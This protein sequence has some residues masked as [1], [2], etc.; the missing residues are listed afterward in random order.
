[1]FAFLILIGLTAHAAEI[2][3]KVVL[4]GEPAVNA[5]ISVEGLDTGGSPDSAAYVVD[6]RDL[7]FVPHVVAAR[8]GA[9]L[10][11]K[12]SD[13]MPCRLY[14]VSPS[15]AFV[16]R[17]QEGKPMTIPLNRPGVIQLR[18]ADH[19]RIHAYVV[20]KENPYFAI[21]D[22]KGEYKIS[23]VPA[24]RHTLQ[25]WYE[26][27]VIKT[28]TVKVGDGELTVD[29]QASQPKMRA[30]ARPTDLFSNSSEATK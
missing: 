9:T 17:R 28:K 11:L 4:S 8:P 20:I 16:M 30:E 12:N 18:C 1:M 24:G 14:S 10:I 3:G 15:G 25:L 19:E 2:T 26:G 5:V 21:T 29:F 22:S 27:R 7:D 23:G 13:G 6:H